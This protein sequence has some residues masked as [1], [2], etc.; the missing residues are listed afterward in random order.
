VCRWAH[1]WFPFSTAETTRDE[2]IG[3][4]RLVAWRKGSTDMG[5]CSPTRASMAA[6]LLDRAPARQGH[7]LPV[8]RLGGAW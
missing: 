2:G 1:A 5:R 7:R 8:A 6:V 3:H 4:G